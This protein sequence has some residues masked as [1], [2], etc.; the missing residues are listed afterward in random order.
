VVKA[1]RKEKFRYILQHGRQKADVVNR[2]ID[3]EYITIR[4]N[5]NR[6]NGTPS[7]EPHV[8]PVQINVGGKEAASV[9]SL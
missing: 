7:N 2:G 6:A 4:Q 1:D 8:G 9:G 3:E 5:E